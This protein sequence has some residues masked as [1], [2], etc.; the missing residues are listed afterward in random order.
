MAR[1]ILSESYGFI[2]DVRRQQTPHFIDV[3]GLSRTHLTGPGEFDHEF[4]VRLKWCNQYAPDFAVEPIGHNAEGKVGKR[5]RFR[6]TPLC[7]LFAATFPTDLRSRST[8][9]L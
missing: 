1:R 8:G 4:S 5:F 7:A 9:R 6:D 3:D 2:D